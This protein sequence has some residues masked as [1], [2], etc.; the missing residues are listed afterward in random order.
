MTCAI[1]F[2]KIPAPTDRGGGNNNL[3]NNRFG[4]NAGNA[5]QEARR[6]DLANAVSAVRGVVSDVP[7]TSENGCDIPG[8]WVWQRFLEIPRN[9]PICGTLALETVLHPAPGAADERL[10]A[11]LV[12]HHKQADGDA[13]QKLRGVMQL[14][15]SL[16]EYQLH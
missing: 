6:D 12:T 4:T 1:E 13:V 14:V 3:W 16:P 7:A 11:D 2:E 15:L 5:D 10:R 9:G 8:R